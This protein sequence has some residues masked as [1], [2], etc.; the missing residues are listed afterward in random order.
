MSAGRLRSAAVGSVPKNSSPSTSTRRTVSPC[1]VTVPFS[2]VTPGSR[3]TRSSAEASGLTGKAA[4]LK[5][6]VSPRSVTR[7]RT[8]PTSTSPSA[9]GTSAT[10]PTSCIGPRATTSRVSAV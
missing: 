2:T 1:A 9:A 5:A 8:A 4:A 10:S 6:V 3:A 7:S